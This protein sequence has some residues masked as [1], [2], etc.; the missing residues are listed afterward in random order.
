MHLDFGP[1]RSARDANFLK[2]QLE[3]N[4]TAVAAI[5]L[6]GTS[7]SVKKMADITSGALA[8]ASTNSTVCVVLQQCLSARLQL[9]ASDDKSQDLPVYAEVSSMLPLDR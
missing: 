4:L 9:N 2:L 1:L 7:P 3:T 8:S 6:L 5:G